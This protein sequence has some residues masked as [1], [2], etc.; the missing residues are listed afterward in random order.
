MK[1]IIC[2]YIHGKANKHNYLI[3]WDQIAYGIVQ[4]KLHYKKKKKDIDMII[5][6]I[7]LVISTVRVIKGRH[8]QRNSSKRKSFSHSAYNSP[9]LDNEKC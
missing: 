3:S 6:L 2:I 9:V 5:G 7:P 4:C 8:R 1:L